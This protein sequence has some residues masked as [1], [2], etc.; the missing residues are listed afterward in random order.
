M[1]FNIHNKIRTR[2]VRK[3]VR[4]SL[5]KDLK[6]ST[7]GI[8]GG[9]LNVLTS[10]NIKKIHDTSIQLL[11]QVGFAEYSQEVEAL[12]TENGGYI[13]TNGRLCFS[14]TSINNS[15]KEL[16]KNFTLFSQDGQ[17]NLIL[18]T[19]RVYFGTG[20][21]SPM[22]RDL[23][24]GALRKSSLKD[25][26]DFARLIDQLDN[27][28]F[29]SRPVVAR[30]MESDDLISIN[31]AYACLIG[32]RKHVIVSANSRSQV[33]QIA[34]MCFLIAGT[35]EK[36]LEKP[37]L[38]IHI[39][40]VVPP[41][42]FSSEAIEVLF[43]SSIQGIP[44]MINTFGQMGASSPVTIA[45]CLAQTNAET[46]AGM[47]I[48]W[49]INPNIKAVYGAR[50]MITDLRTGGMAGGSGEQALLTSGAI[51]LANYYGFSNSTIAG[52]TDSKMPDA[53]AGFEKALNI[54]MAAN[55]GSNLITQAAGTQAGLMVSSFESSVIDNDMLGGISRSVSKIVV[56]EETLSFE[57]IKEKVNTDGHFLGA[58][59]TF[60]RMKSDFLYPE[61]LDRTPYDAWES[62]D[63]IGIIDRAKVLAK[64]ILE[65]HYPN[66]VKDDLIKQ[67]TKEFD[68]RIS[69]NEMRKI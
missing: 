62:S 24:T 50:P 46:L 43:E 54:N 1:V 18:S 2:R 39:N 68:I 29:F 27:I 67:I 28:H 59:E 33:R 48:S 40:H 37:F 31:T 32:T 19:G 23:E 7:K 4:K 13:N 30:D 9:K 34:K 35:K 41:M 11:T 55:S 20:G 56:D 5:S 64:E 44:V 57:L 49:L 22:V 21:A 3:K 14:K 36:Y 66:H 47:T 69:T 52:A 38:S 60:E 6:P 53:Q 61:I 17:N 65:S 8:K 26:Y 15:I 16:K 25:I 42:R 10:D 45:G 51:Q 58:N 63:R 12:V